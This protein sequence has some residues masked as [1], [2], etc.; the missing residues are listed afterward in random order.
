MSTHQTFSWTIKFV[1]VNGFVAIEL[2][3]NEK[4]SEVKANHLPA[5][6][7]DLTVHTTNIFATPSAE[8][9]TF[10]T[11]STPFQYEETEC[12]AELVAFAFSTADLTQA[13]GKNKI[14]SKVSHDI[15]PIHG[16]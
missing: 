16:I 6:L 12:S 2:T 3:T 15:G 4:V 11:I 8:G 13:K 5:C 14:V 7:H 10:H 1:N 9:S